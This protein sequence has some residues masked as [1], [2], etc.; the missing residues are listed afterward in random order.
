MRLVHSQMKKATILLVEDELILRKNLVRFFRRTGHEVVCAGDSDEAL[1]LLRQQ[2]FNVLITDLVV[3][4]GE[5]FP[6]MA[7]AKTK[8]VKIIVITAYGSPHIEDTLRAG[9]VFAY[10]EKP[11]RLETLLSTVEKILIEWAPGQASDRSSSM[12]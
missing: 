5:V 12:S 8:G 4:R 3:P 11:L 7:E 1:H 2:P 6:L 10:L 9:G